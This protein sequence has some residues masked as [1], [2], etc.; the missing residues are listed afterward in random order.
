VARDLEE[1]STHLIVLRSGGYWRG[2]QLA[3]RRSMMA[4]APPMHIC[5]DSD[6]LKVCTHIIH[7]AHTNS[8]CL[9]ILYLVRIHPPHMIDLII[10]S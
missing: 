5:M 1:P 4:A 6:W 3:I 10:P 9:I 8:K 2:S 7:D